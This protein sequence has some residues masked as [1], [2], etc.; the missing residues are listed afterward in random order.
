MPE[1][2]L[3]LWFR[4]DLRL[5]D[6]RALAAALATGQPVVP[7]YVL[8]DEAPGTWRM[9]GASRWWLHGSLAALAR[10]LEDRGA[11]LVLRKGKSADILE[12]LAAETGARTVFCSRAYEPWAAA[13]E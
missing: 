2:P 1:S 3:I 6:N 9:G 13:L 4:N 10:D 11:R 8:D 5:T 7:V 12:A